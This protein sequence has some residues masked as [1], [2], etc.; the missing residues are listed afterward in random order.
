MS[1]REKSP[2]LN[3]KD[4]PVW[5]C[6]RVRAAV[7]EVQAGRMPTLAVTFVRVAREPEVVGS[8]R[9]NLEFGAM[10]QQ[11]ES[12]CTVEAVS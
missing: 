9:D 10:Q 4:S 7:A 1:V 12:L 6:E 2:P 11:I 3:S 8:E 5:A